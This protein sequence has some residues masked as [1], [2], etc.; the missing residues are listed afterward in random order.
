MPKIQVENKTASHRLD[1]VRQNHRRS[2]RAAEGTV[3]VG[4]PRIA[5]AVIAHVIPQD[6][7]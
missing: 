2:Q 4:Q 5:A 7:P 1:H 3:K 6:I